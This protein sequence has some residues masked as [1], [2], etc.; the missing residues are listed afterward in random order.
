MAHDVVICMKIEL[1]KEFKS[2]IKIEKDCENM[3]Y[4][5]EKEGN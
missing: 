1:P 4:K 3:A 2:D 5:D